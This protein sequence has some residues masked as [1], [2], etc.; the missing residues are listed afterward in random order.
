MAANTHLEH[1][2]DDILNNGTAGG[3][4]AIAFL[5]ELGQMLTEPNSTIRITTKWDG[6]PAIVCG[7]HPSTGNFFVGTKS[8][9][10]KGA[11][12][13]CFSNSDIDE[14]YN[15]ELAHKLKTCLKLLPQLGIKGV[16]Q[17]D[18]LYTNDLGSKTINGEKCVS[19]TPNTITYAVPDKSPLAMKIKASQMGIVF[20]TTYSGGPAVRDMSASFGANVSKMQGNK[21]VTVF[22]SD[23]SDA[24]GSSL[25]SS[26]E[27]AR[28][29]AAVNKTEGSLK[30][31]SKFLD[32]LNGKQDGR[33]LFSALFK[34][35][36]N[37]FIRGG[38]KIQNVQV[39]AMGFTKFY[40]DLLDKEIATKKQEG[41]KKKYKLIKTEGLKFLK[42]NYRAI[43]MTVA[44]YMNLIAAKNM[45]IR[46]LEKVKGIG[47]YIKTDTGFKVTAPE[48]FVAIKSGSALK[49]VDRLEFS[50]VN[51][52]IEKNWG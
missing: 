33:F 37:S 3:K 34:Q 44:S 21:N 45:V 19:F 16:L 52:N 38:K 43:Y 49:L 22:S 39:V 41:T 29:L 31:A 6:A 8:V 51:F 32:I 17:G 28:Y 47:T 5:R 46:Q 15:G 42:V 4:N 7:Q 36:F 27:K 20:H 40:T 1:L 25:F 11:P 24:T 14:W 10:N 35:Y 30:Q 9:F 12:K 2:E 23:F 50:R 18:L 48:G 13:I 26:N